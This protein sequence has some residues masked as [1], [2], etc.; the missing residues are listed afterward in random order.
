MV[1]LSGQVGGGGGMR[2]VR[3]QEYG[4][5]T[6]S[7]MVIDLMQH[8]T[9]KFRRYSMINMTNMYALC[10]FNKA[11]CLLETVRDLKSMKEHFRSR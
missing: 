2:H 5:K 9:H 6:A 3:F 8:M 11:S 1:S 7:T 4:S 10:C